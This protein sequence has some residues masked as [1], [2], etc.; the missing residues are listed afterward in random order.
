MWLPTV[1]AVLATTVS[2]IEQHEHP[3]NYNAA[4]ERQWRERISM[5]PRGFRLSLTGGGPSEMLLS[6]TFTLPGQHHR[7]DRRQH[8][9]LHY[10]TTSNTTDGGKMCIP[11]TIAL[12]AASRGEVTMRCLMTGLKPYTKYFYSVST[13]A[14]PSRRAATA[15]AATTST[16]SFVTAPE[17]GGAFT[18]SMY[19]LK[20]I[21]FGDVDWTDGKA[22][23]TAPGSTNQSALEHCVWGGAPPHSELSRRWTAPL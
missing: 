18:G 9:V 8:Q 20:I 17:S 16:R 14:S 7:Q 6:W 5:T 12:P 19:P 4:I 11:E 23:G 15:T 13:S 10:S 3:D 2:T 22:G 1:L 21:A